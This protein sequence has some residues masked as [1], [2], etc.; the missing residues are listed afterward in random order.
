VI[1]DSSA[2][3]AVIL[4]EPGRER[5]E[6]ALG[7]APSPGVGGPTLAEAGILLVARLGLR[8]RTLLDAFLVETG[9]VTIPFGDAH[10][11]VALDAFDRFGKGRH[12]ASL[13]LGDCM[14]Y[15]VARLA[16]EPLLCTG[17]DFARTDLALVA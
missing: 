17:G 13:N 6:E 10:W 3:V 16:G 7:A 2:I 14:T 12:P 8:G 11:I 9:S 5:I 4:D 1:L 15:A